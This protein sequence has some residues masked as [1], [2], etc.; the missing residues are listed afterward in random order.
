MCDHPQAFEVAL[1]KLKITP[2]QLWTDKTALTNLLRSVC[3]RSQLCRRANASKGLGLF[4]RAGGLSL[5]TT[6][7][8]C[9]CSAVTANC[10]R[11][12]CY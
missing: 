3:P 8:S 2:S 12:R 1:V 5:L 11:Q 4:Q 7:M 10:A 9:L 6:V